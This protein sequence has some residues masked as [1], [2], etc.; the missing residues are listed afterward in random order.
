MQTRLT[1]L[2]GIRH[3]VV[4][5]PMGGVAGG[6]LAAAVARA[7][8]LGLIGCGYGDPRAGYG[9]REWISAQ[10]DEAGNALLDELTFEDAVSPTGG[11]TLGYTYRR[12]LTSGSA[13]FRPI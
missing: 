4:L 10:F 13:A 1:D 5:A 3:P 9:S 8:G 2:F 7:G 12:L 11:G 6:A